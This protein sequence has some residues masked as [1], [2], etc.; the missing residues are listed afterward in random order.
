MPKVWRNWNAWPL[1]VGMYN[2]KTAVE[3]MMIP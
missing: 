1:P 2:G 3:D